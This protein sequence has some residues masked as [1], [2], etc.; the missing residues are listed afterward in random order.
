[1]IRLAGV[2][3]RYPRTERPALQDIDLQVSA[4]EFVG[5][6]GAN[7]SGKSSLCLA[8]S[9]FIP[10]F[11]KGRLEGE[12]EVAGHPVRET[13]LGTMAGAVGLVFQNPFNQIS[14]ARF[15]VRE[16]VAFGL[17]NMGVPPPEMASRV[18]TALAQTGL[19]DQ[20]GHSPY[21]LSGGQQQR[22]AIASVVVLRPRLF[23][24]DEPTSQL[25]PVGTR[26]VYAALRA[27]VS[28][29]GHTVVCATHKLE[30]L[31]SFADRIVL[32]RE[33][34]MIADDHPRRVLT[35]PDLRSLGIAPTRYTA[36]ALEAQRQ[37]FRENRGG[38]LPVTLDQAAAFFDGNQD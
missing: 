34:K 20:A 36:A 8:L 23:V 15:T 19:R 32:L 18:D 9:G 1:M 21:A 22:L 4:G 33:G 7:G 28:E 37:G 5:L 25:D 17:E 38:E 12:I 24:L 3:Y 16:E 30:W 13:P 2:T 29:G 10:H 6:I 27:L 31:A 35:R 14:G 26:E 11:Y